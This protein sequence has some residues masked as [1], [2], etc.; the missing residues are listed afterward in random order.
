MAD[1]NGFF[2]LSKTALTRRT[3]LKGL[4]A[5]GA[6]AAAGGWPGFVAGAERRA[7]QARL[8]GRTAPASAP[9]TAAGTSAPPPPRSRC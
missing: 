2:D 6:L 3:A 7:D 8:P 1:K 5:G 9:P 4:A